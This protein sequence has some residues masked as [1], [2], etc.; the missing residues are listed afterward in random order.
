MSRHIVINFLTDIIQPAILPPAHIQ[1]IS[2]YF[3]LQL[4]PAKHTWHTAHQQDSNKKHSINHFSINASL[5]QFTIFKLPAAYHTVL[6]R[7]QLVILEGR[8]VY[9]KQIS[10]TNKHICRIAVYFSLRR[11]IFNIIPATIVAG[12][13]SEY[14]TLYR[15]CL[16]F[17]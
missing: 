6:S 4:L 11:N 13:M 15:I 17:F 14:K 9:Y 7:N 10:F 16:R 12:H 3:T 8:L 2:N 1:C 5:D